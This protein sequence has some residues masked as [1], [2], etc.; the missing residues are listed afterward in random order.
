MCK[1]YWIHDEATI[2]RKYIVPVLR[3]KSLEDVYEN[4]YNSIGYSI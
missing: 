3:E 1:L 4:E 2:L